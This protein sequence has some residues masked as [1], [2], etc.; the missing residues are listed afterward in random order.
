HW[1]RS[2]LHI[3]TTLGQPAT[4]SIRYLKRDV[5]ILKLRLQLNEKLVDDALDH[6]M[7]QAAKLND[8]VETVTE[9]WREALLD[10]LHRI[11]GMILVSEANRRA[12]RSLSPSVGGHDEYDV[13]EINLTTVIVRQR[14]VIHYLQ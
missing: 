6:L 2:H 1:T 4:R 8:R 3:I 13:S 5:L 12:R 7:A 14:P 9:L 11:R 10:D